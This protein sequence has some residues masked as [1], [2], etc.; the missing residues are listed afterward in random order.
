MVNAKTIRWRASLL[1]ND[2]R[3]VGSLLASHNESVHGVADVFAGLQSTKVIGCE[4][5]SICIE[6]AGARMIAVQVKLSLTA[7]REIAVSLFGYDNGGEGK[8]EQDGSSETAHGG[9][10]QGRTIAPR[11]LRL[12]DLGMG[13]GEKE[14][15][16]IAGH[17]LPHCTSKSPLPLLPSGPGGVGG[18]VSRGTDVRHFQ[19][20]ISGV[21]GGIASRSARA[22]LRHTRTLVTEG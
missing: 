3:A 13:A 1:T 14:G 20:N 21:W 8:G 19:Y 16:K 22:T 17:R 12:K 5:A 6:S 11:Q 9:P 2:T 4:E 18:N 10:P 7:L 15:Q